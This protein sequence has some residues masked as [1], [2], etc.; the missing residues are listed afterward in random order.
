MTA[1]YQQVPF[2]V[3]MLS[4]HLV[5]N[6]CQTYRLEYILYVLYYSTFKFSY[7]FIFFP[8]IN[9]T[10]ATYIHTYIFVHYDSSKCSTDMKRTEFP[11]IFQNPINLVE[12]VPQIVSTLHDSSCPE[13]FP[14]V[15][16]YA[17]EDKKYAVAHCDWTQC[18]WNYYSIVHL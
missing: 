10:S 15:I 13:T 6:L 12:A 9:C 1:N 8:F 5:S 16:W 7:H 18:I 17:T 3:S 2:L 11:S 14:F 4:L